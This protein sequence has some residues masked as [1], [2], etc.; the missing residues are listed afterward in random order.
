V[1]L[2]IVLLGYLYSVS[3]NAVV[4]QPVVDSSAIEEEELVECT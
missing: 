1:L 4:P 2:P 3:R